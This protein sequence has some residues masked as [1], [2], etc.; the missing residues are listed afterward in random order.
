MKKPQNV[1]EFLDRVQDIS[2]DS[3]KPLK[4]SDII[5]DLESTFKHIN[6]QKDKLQSNMD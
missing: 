6:D 5:T 3:G 4:V 2:D 1:K